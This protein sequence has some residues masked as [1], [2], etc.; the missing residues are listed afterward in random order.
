MKL[1]NL[2]KIG[3]ALALTLSLVLSTIPMAHDEYE[4]SAETVTK[5]IGVDIKGNENRAVLD[6]PD[7]YNWTTGLNLT[8][9]T[10]TFDGVTCTLSSPT[11]EVFNGSQNKTLAKTDGTTPYITCDGIVMTGTIK[12]EISGLSAGVH[13]LT[14]WHSYYNYGSNK[15]GEIK[16]SINGK[17]ST[18]VNP[19]VKAATDL[20]ASIAYQEFEVAEGETVTVLIEK[21]AGT[22]LYANPVLNGFEIDGVHPTKAIKNP[23]P[24]NNE[25]HHDEEAGLT[26][27]G[28]DGAV[29]H[30]LYLGEDEMA[31]RAATTGSAEYKGK[32][33]ESKYAFDTELDHMKTYY[34]RVDE[35]F[36]DGSVAKGTVMTFQVRHLAFPTAEGYGRFAKGGRGGKVIEVTTLEDGY[37]KITNEDGSTTTY[38]IKGSL[39]YA[40]EYETGPRIVVFKVGGVIELQKKLIIDSSH[41]NVYVAG[42]TAPGD[43]IT[44]IN[45]SLGML[46]ANDVIIRNVRVRVGD[47]NGVACDGMG[48][49]SCNNCIIDHCSI[50]WGTDE[51][52]SSRG[53]QNITLQYTIIAESLHESVHYLPG[54]VGE[55][56]EGVSQ[57][58][59][60]ASV[61]GNIGS[62]HHNLLTNCTGRN[63]SLA[64]AMESDNKTYGGYMDIS[65]NVIYN[66]TNR[67]TDGGVRRLNFVNNYYKMGHSSRDMYIISIDGDAFNTGD[68]QMMYVSGNKLVT[69][70]GT[71]IL[72]ATDDAWAKGY[73]IPGQ[74][75]T[76]ETCK[77]DEPFFPSY[78][79]L[80]SADDAYKTV[81]ANAGARVPSL[82]Y[83]DSRY[84]SEVE[85]GTYTYTGSK[86]N[87]PG[88]ADSQE[89]VGGY[90][91]EN[92]FKG[93]E[94]VLDTD[95]D[96]MPDEWEIEHGLNPEDYSD[97]SLFTLSAE[98][99]TNVE[100]YLNELMGDPLVWADPVVPTDTPAPTETAT[101]EATEISYLLGDVNADGKINSQDALLVLKH[102]AK[103]IELNETEKKAADVTKEESIN[104]SD[105]L[106]ILRYAARIITEFK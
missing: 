63:W 22:T 106:E 99:Y 89:D 36:E 23:V 61:S 32:L 69:R 53:A 103:I 49:G 42:Q 29:A 44:L 28:A 38:P 12:L 76:I 62:L 68:R 8:S 94:A 81:L 96:G 66:Y 13:T 60:A 70:T 30:N 39:R 41:D 54:A 34:W 40:L 78:I 35:I 104:A 56:P 97:N 33:M 25:G 105:A 14:T 17:V 64:G 85:N 73:A 1:N 55:R 77:S 24:V 46:G 31:V 10:E 79:T 83:L 72:D 101:P 27:V 82:D 11:G 26:W 57:H 88:I 74:W 16:V 52:F 93:A 21:V 95:H 45:Y 47:M 19:S 86:T 75:G 5:N 59:F 6:S 50:A 67:T 9:I 71:A 2:G 51:G 102:A 37:E 3:I 91:N 92:N 65:N 98:G 84:V 4:V 87:L 7:F 80:E 43:G 18:V 100:M 15:I 90:P 20:A 48:M 58:S